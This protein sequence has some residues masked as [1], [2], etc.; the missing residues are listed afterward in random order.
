MKIQKTVRILGMGKYLPK[1][2]VDSA[3]LESRLGIPPGWTM[4]YTGVRE[5]HHSDE[6]SGAFMGARALEE[7]LDQADL[8]FD[9]L[10]LLLCASTTFDYLIPNQACVIKLEVKG[11]T[12]TDVPAMTVDSTCLSF[13]AAFDLA[14]QLMNGNRY[15]KIGI[16]SV[17]IASKGL[18]PDD[19]ET[20]TLFGDGAAAVILAWSPEEES[21]VIQAGMKTWSEGVFNTQVKGGGNAYFFKDYP[22]DAALHSFSMKGKNLLRLAQAKIPEFMD[23]F[24]C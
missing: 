9:E 7:A 6:E 8:R 20:A 3:T 23:H 14:T 1:N 12:A 10:D 5:R 22:Y 16:V 13:V 19:W 11:G 17:E 21:G 15:R 18:N 4:R 24:F 2:K